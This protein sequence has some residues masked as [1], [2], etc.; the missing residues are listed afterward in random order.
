MKRGTENE[1]E[2]VSL[3]FSFAWCH[4]SYLRFPFP[5]SL[6]ER[7]REAYNIIWRSGKVPRVIK[8]IKV[9]AFFEI[10]HGV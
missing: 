3:S 4:F 1:N 7:M 5:T 6:N 10:A 9:L 2:K 8:N